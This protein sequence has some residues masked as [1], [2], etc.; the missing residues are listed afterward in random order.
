MSGANA[1]PVGRSHQALP[2]LILFLWSAATC[3]A[4]N[5]THRGFAATRFTFYPQ[6]APNDSAHAI[7]EALFRY[8]GF[9]NVSNSLQF[10]GSVDARTD[11]H[12]QVDRDVNLSW[13]DRETR[14]PLVAVRRFS[15][16]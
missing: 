12:H 6:E 3:F 16:T 8:E 4:Q 1:S 7:G 9:Y 15:G 10:A 11:T 13:W 14:R 5:Y 2:V